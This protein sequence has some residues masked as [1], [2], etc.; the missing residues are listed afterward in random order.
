MQRHQVLI[1][2]LR[3]SNCDK[4]LS[5]L[6]IRKWSRFFVRQRSRQQLCSNTA[7]YNIL[8]NSSGKERNEIQEKGDRDSINEIHIYF[9]SVRN[10]HWDWYLKA[11]R[12]Q[13]K[14]NCEKF[15]CNIFE[16]YWGCIHIPKC[17]CPFHWL[18]VIILLF[19]FCK[20]MGRKLKILLSFYW[21]ILH[22]IF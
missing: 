20:R 19:F 15:F 8:H 6:N 14:F 11:M 12:I 18:W 5:L 2:E 21:E 9:I 1:K 17:E 13:L 4:M 16:M 10:T 3:L 22:I 7:Q